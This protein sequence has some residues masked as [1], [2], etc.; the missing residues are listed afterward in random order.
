[1]GILTQDRVVVELMTAKKYNKKYGVV[2]LDALE[3]AA[4]AKAAARAEKRAAA[5]A[6]ARREV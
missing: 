1:M 4:R 2:D 3:A 5:A 6:Q